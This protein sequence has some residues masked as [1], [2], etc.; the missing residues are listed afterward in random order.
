MANFLG[1]LGAAFAGQQKYQE[2]LD[3]REAAKQRIALEKL[4]L[5]ETKQLSEQA[6]KQRERQPQVDQSVL[7]Y[8]ARTNQGIPPPPP[9]PPP[10]QAPPPGQQSQ[11]M[12]QQPVPYQMQPG[13]I[14]GM[15]GPPPGAMQG[16]QAG[17]QGI[18]P[19]PQGMPPQG[20]PQMP[21]GGVP[22][23]PPIMGGP[24]GPGGPPPAPPGPQ[25]QPPIPPY[26][27][28]GGAQLPQQ[29]QMP[30]GLPPPPPQEPQQPPMPA[31]N[32]MSL[33]DA[34][35]FIKAQGITDP[36]T[37]IQILDKLTPF[38]DKKAQREAQVIKLQQ[39]FML[40]RA[41]LEERAR[42]ADLRSKDKNLSI[43]QQREWR[44]QSVLARRDIAE[45]ANETKR[46]LGFMM[47]SIAQ[48]NANTRKEAAGGGG[49]GLTPEEIKYWAGVQRAGGNLPPRLDKADQRAIMKEV[50]GGSV[51]PEEMLAN[52]ANQAGRTAEQRTIGTTAGNVS[53]AGFEAENAAKI[54]H[55]QAQKVYRTT[56]VPVNKAINAFQEKTGDPN[57]RAFG[58][59]I[60]TFVNTY[61]RAIS[62]KGVATVS[63]KQHAR[64]MLDKADSPKAFD[65]IMNVLEQEM[66]MAQ[67]VPQMA[68]DKARNETLGTKPAAATPLQNGW[69]VK[70]KQ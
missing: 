38:L 31:P 15:Q 70:V 3:E 39:E 48:Q 66:A 28:M 65:A 54:L 2:Y 64:D 52:R 36:Q 46:M 30:Q 17:P 56:F 55:D 41:K 4:R 62:P 63:D 14:P 23:L 26:Q 7:D 13:P 34:A 18:P 57:T 24:M 35:Q 27:T 68:R 53:M 5:E 43:E 20:P 58:A 49:G 45:Q 60:N 10:V 67:K 51:T 50:A 37:G 19:P 21:P 16:P 40:E 32:S 42:E 6:K 8:L 33:E 59:A 11:P 61:A 47:G 29:Q 9:M 22:G 1:N 44:E 12:E 69:T 25:Q